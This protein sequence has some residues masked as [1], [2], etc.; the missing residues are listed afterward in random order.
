MD[1][2]HETSHLHKQ[3]TTHPCTA[4]KPFPETLFKVRKGK[5]GAHLASF[6]RRNSRNWATS[7][8]TNIAP[9]IQVDGTQQPATIRSRGYTDKGVLWK[10]QSNIVGMHAGLH[11]H[12]WDRNESGEKRR[13]G[14]N[15]NV[16]IFVVT[17]VCP[18]K[19][20]STLACVHVCCRACVHGGTCAG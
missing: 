9:V 14:K 13:W 11:A 8:S 18:C 6:M 4:M 15:V 16:R 3:I 2:H 1:Q 20:K 10:S 19:Q 12:P 7:C 5:K 17:C